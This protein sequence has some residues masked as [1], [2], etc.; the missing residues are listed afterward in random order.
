MREIKTDYIVKVENGP[1]CDPEFA[2]EGTEKRCAGYMLM[3][4]NEDKDL[5]MICF[6]GL[7]VADMKDA[8]RS[9]TDNKCVALMRMAFVLAEAEIRSMDIERQYAAEKSA[10]RMIKVLKG[11]D[12]DELFPQD[13][14]QE[15]PEE[16]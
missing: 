3:T 15:F 10:R 13:E 7:S 11:E 5:S 14:T 1:E 6:N 9:N 8:I 16:E 2:D 4:F 12:P